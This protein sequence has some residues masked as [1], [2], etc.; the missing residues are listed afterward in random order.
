[1]DKRND[2]TVM[3][4]PNATPRNVLDVDSAPRF[5]ACQ[6][7]DNG[8]GETVMLSLYAP[9]EWYLQADKYDK[10]FDDEGDAYQWLVDNSFTYV[11]IDEV[12][13]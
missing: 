9:G 6:V 8:E 12:D 10:E 5:P 1:M 4:N 2:P 7:F 13:V 11:G 3:V